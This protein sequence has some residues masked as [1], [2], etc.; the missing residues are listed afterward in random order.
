MFFL[1]QNILETINRMEIY[2]NSKKK[3]SNKK[4]VVWK[5]KDS[6]TSILANLDNQAELDW[7]ATMHLW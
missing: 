4:F 1:K 6:D 5:K 7:E 3:Y 2:K